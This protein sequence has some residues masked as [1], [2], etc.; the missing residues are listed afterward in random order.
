[1]SYLFSFH[2][3]I[4]RA[5]L[6]LFILIAL[7]VDIVYII[8]FSTLIGLSALTSMSHNAGGLAAAGGTFLI[9]LILGCVLYIALFV[10]GLA[11]TTKRLH[12]RD[13]S[14]IWLLV[15]IVAPLVINVYVFATMI[16]SAGLDPQQMTAAASANPILLVGRLVAG[17]LSIWGFVELYCLRGTVG[18]NR[19]GP[20][21][22]AGLQQ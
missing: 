7:G 4:N 6:W 9:F 14:A 19:Y 5:K 8:L 15:F 10:A 2:G 16:A 12:D 22:L 3:R 11:L 18:D 13:K 21:P 20:D 17:V 1:M